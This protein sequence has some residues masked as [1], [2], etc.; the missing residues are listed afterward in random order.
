MN[1]IILYIALCAWLIPSSIQVH[2]QGIKI[3]PGTTFKLRGGTYNLIL[4]GNAHFENNAVIQTEDLVLKAS[5]NGSSEIKGTGPLQL[6]ELQ[7]AKSVGQQ[8]LLLKDLDITTAVTFNS[9]LVDLNG[10]DLLLAENA[11]LV[12][13][14]EA[15]HITGSAGGAVQISRNL[16]APLAENP[17]NM[18]LIIT[19]GADWGNTMIRRGHDTYSDAGGAGSIAR[20]FEITPT[21]NAN[22]S[23]FLR[24]HYLDAELNGLEE[25][26]LDFYQSEDNGLSWDNIANN[27]SNAANNFVNL[28]GVNNMAFFTLSTIDAPLALHLTDIGAVCANGQLLLYWHLPTPANEDYFRIQKSRDGQVWETQADKITVTQGQAYQYIDTAAP[29]PYY[30]LQCTYMDGQVTYSTILQANCTM[31]GYDFTLLQNPITNSVPISI[32]TPVAVQLTVSIYDQEGRRLLQQ[33][34][35]LD[36]GE[37]RIDIDASGIASGMYFIQVLGVQGRLWQA[38]FVK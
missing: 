13:E 22:L 19:S 27:G 29:Y 35:Q 26:A 10:H 4:S 12:N 21:N 23:A 32:K 16:N 37:S 31:S 3:M 25:S 38:K 20:N 5:G 17:G 14:T 7:V 33:P 8:V 15:S 36:A 24:M 2:A 6:K 11:L 30:R 18:G 34:E 28:N 1:K 9:G